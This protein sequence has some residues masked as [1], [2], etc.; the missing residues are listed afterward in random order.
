MIFV[1]KL[2]FAIFFNLKDKMMNSYLG[3]KFS[4]FSLMILVNDHQGSKTKYN[5]LISTLIPITFYD[6]D[7]ER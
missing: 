5:Y 4:L 2:P 1:V 6:L 7:K 3:Q